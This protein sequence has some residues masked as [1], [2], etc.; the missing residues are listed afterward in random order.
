V[1]GRGNSVDVNDENSLLGVAQKV[2]GRMTC[3][4]RNAK[5]ELA[6]RFPCARATLL[7][8]NSNNFM[9]RL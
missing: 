3:A 9:T 1:D 7:S 2:S 8:A 5:L 4:E 6:F